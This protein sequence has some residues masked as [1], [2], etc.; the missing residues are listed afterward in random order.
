MKLIL[1]CHSSALEASSEK[2]TNGSSS[3][4]HNYDRIDNNS[5][6]SIESSNEN[7]RKPKNKNKNE[8]YEDEYGKCKTFSK[9]GVRCTDHI[10]KIKNIVEQKFEIPYDEQLLVYKDKILNHDHKQLKAYH[11]RNYGRIHVF[12]KRDVKENLDDIDP[13]SID[14]EF[15]EELANNF[16]SP[17]P[18]PIKD[19]KKEQNIEIKRTKEASNKNT[20]DE[21]QCFYAQKST[22]YSIPDIH[23]HSL[24]SRRVRKLDELLNN[25][26]L[27]YAK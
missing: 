14:Q 17:P 23:K 7:E 2:N 5:S 13:Y 25:S 3:D 16:S 18:Q 8:I 15:V 21:S 1:L 20:Y 6:S 22:K 27:M 4:E 26:S 10:E 12:D 9:I 24:S 19:R 11:I